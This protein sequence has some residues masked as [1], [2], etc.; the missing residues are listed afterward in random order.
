MRITSRALRDRRAALSWWLAG[1]IVYSGFIIAV[2]PVIDGNQE[3]EDIYADMPDSIQA[4]FGPDG[5]TS[6]TSPAG[7]LNGYLFSMILPFILTGLAISMGSALL[8]GEEEEGLVELALS[9]PIRRRRLLLEKAT[10]IVVALVGMGAALLLFLAVA[11]EPVDLDIGVAG[12]AVA[13]LG[14][15]LFALANG[16]VALLAGAWRGVQGLATG[17][18]WG[19]ALVGYLINVLANLDDS[20]DGLKYASPLYW[21]TAGQ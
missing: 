8:A 3:L 1:V 10:A 14:S 20:L 6:L 17:V 11:R 16:V 15:V 7:F 18:A 9:Y 2:W 13:T 19:V 5:L 21:A 12:L 4:L